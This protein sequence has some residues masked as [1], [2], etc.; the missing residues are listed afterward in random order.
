MRN[1]T[2]G[3]TYG[4]AKVSDQQSGIWSAIA[5]VTIYD[6]FLYRII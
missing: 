1:S 6:S 3:L 2:V 4:K 5:E